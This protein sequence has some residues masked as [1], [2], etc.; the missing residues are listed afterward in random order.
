M[1]FDNPTPLL[2]GFNY[3]KPKT[4]NNISP[5]EVEY[6]QQVRRTGYDFDQMRNMQAQQSMSD[7][8]VDFQNEFNSCSSNIQQR[9][10]EDNDFRMAMSECDKQIQSM[11]ENL[12][13]PQV[14]QTK[15][16]RLAFERLLAVFRKLKEGYSH[17][18]AENMKTI[19][20]LMQDEVVL[21]RLAELKGEGANIDGK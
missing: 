1:G 17:Q 19:N 6:I 14:M 3:S 15:D 2:G 12:V 7:P 11:V 16:G 18:E 9:I 20:M 8:Y 13:R 4:M 10:M 5:Q 21:K